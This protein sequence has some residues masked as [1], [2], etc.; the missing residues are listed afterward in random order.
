MCDC[1]LLLN[2]VNSSNY[3]DISG[4]YPSGERKSGPRLDIEAGDLTDLS[5]NVDPEMN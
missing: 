2:P 4:V 3:G 1:F 5:N